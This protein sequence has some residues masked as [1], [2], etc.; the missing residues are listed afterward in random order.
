MELRN[1]NIM[2]K[3]NIKKKIIY[4]TDHIEKKKKFFNFDK[5]KKKKKRRIDT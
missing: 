1:F 2:M 3:Y 5:K 4:N